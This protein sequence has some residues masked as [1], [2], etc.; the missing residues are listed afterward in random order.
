[1][2]RGRKTGASRIAERRRRESGLGYVEVLIATVLVAI[3][4][5][6]MLEGLSVG[7]RGS[8]VRHDSLEGRLRAASRM[9]EVLAQPF[10]DLDAEALAVGD[11]STAS[12]YS[13]APGTPQRRLVFLSRY[14]GDDAD[15]DGDPFTDVDEDLVWVSVAIENSVHVLTT[16][17][18]R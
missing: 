18:R 8:A 4:L 9:E 5:V 1:M 3:A 6:P 15:G 11:P 17:T 7:M 2:N 16:L 10:A 14:D 12:S 13:D